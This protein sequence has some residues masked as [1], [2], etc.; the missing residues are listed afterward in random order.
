MKI[1]R[2]SAIYVMLAAALGVV[3]TLATIGAL[4]TMGRDGGV[5]GVQA[6]LYRNVQ[7][8]EDG[9]HTS[10]DVGTVGLAVRKDTATALA[11]TDG[12]YVPVIVDSS[13]RLWTKI[14]NTS[15]ITVTLDGEEVDMSD[16]LT[17]LLGKTTNYDVLANGTI[18]NTVGT[19]EM[20]G[21]GLSTIGI[22]V[23][24]SW[25][26]T[27]VAE[28]TA[29]DGVWDPIP[30]VDNTLGS[31]ALS[32]T[33]NGNYLLGVAGSLTVRVRATAWTSG[34]ATIYAEG[35][36]APAGVFLSRSI[37][38]GLNSIG[39]VGLN[40]G[41]ASI[42]KLGANSG[43]DIG[44]VTLNNIE[45]VTVTLDSETVI[46]DSELAAAAALADDAAN[47]TVPTVGAGQLLYNSTA[48]DS[49][50]DRER[51]NWS[52]WP[53]PSLQ[54]TASGTVSL[55]NY[56]AKG[57]YIVVNITGIG[58]NQS[59]TVKG[60]VYDYD[61]AGTEAS[62]QMET[63]WSSAALTPTGRHTY[64]IYPGAGAAAQDVVAT[65][66]YPLPRRWVIG[67]V[68]NNSEPITF[69]IGVHYIN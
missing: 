53:F 54:R 13:G 52:I 32:T 66:S 45:D 69:S 37:P 18:T 27:L 60:Y 29:G 58:L 3:L 9:A 43:T 55:V 42:G 65:V 49:S 33:S 40:A 48:V 21:A 41:T 2:R 4:V 19:V 20:A 26:G 47:P 44:D 30:L 62:D 59:L 64:L 15:D 12:D 50:F 7:Y 68:L 35:T 39:T 31:A 57:A 23:S 63:I 38:T 10:G 36:S 17:R 25:A 46:V 8:Q 6:I 16:D 22:G 14:G 28:T 67:T 11:G 61:G 5:P 56:N 51:N 1:D 34:T 24:G